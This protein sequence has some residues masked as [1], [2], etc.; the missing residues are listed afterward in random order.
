MYWTIRQNS[1]ALK[2]RHTEIWGEK[3]LTSS[4]GFSVC[5]IQ[6]SDFT[7]Y[8]GHHCYQLLMPIQPFHCVTGFL[9]QQ[10]KTTLLHVRQLYI[11]YVGY[12]AWQTSP[13]YRA[14]QSATVFVTSLYS[15]TQRS[16]I[17]VCYVAQCNNNC[18]SEF[19]VAD[20]AIQKYL[21]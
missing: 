19:C 17:S 3:Q 12:V 2:K 5:Y 1:Y 11:G 14:L 9:H 7:K 18:S 8:N 20:I 21:A 4:F 10:K 6:N 13:V 15:M 16:I